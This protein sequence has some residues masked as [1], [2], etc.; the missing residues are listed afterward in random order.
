[1]RLLYSPTRLLTTLL[2]LLVALVLVPVHHKDNSWWLTSL[3]V[4]GQCLVLGWTAQRIHHYEVQVGKTTL[5]TW[6]WVL[7]LLFTVC[8]SFLLW[9][10]SHL[11][12]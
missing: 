8:F 9:L 7:V 3:V 10:F 2:P 1:V 6:V 5:A 11:A 4:A 12:L